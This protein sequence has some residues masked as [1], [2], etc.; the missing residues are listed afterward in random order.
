M[1]LEIVADGWRDRERAREKEED[2]D[3]QSMEKSFQLCSWLNY[4]ELLPNV[5]RVFISLVYLKCV[6]HEIWIDKSFIGTQMDTPWN[7]YAYT[8]WDI[9]IC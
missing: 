7:R 5:L 1:E 2:R 9:Y 8:S 3:G 4:F 6:L